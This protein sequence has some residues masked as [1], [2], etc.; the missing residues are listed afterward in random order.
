V[1]I[2][3]E[4]IDKKKLTFSFIAIGLVCL[5]LLLVAEFLVRIFRPQPVLYPRW[6]YS[7]E[8][9]HVLYKNA[10]MK[11]KGPGKWQFTY[12]INEYGYRGKK[13]PISNC[14]Q[15][16]TIVVLGDS[17][18]FGTGVDDGEEYPSVM[19]NYLSDNYDIIN[20]AVGGYGLTQEIRRFYE[21]GQLY[22]P[23]IVILQFCGNDPTENFYHRVTEIEDGIFIFKDTNN[24]VDWVKQYFSKSIIQRSQ[25]YSLFRQVAYL[26]FKKRHI[27]TVRTELRQR[28]SEESVSPREEFHNSLLES[29]AKDLSGKGT[30]LMMISVN[31]QLDGF[32][33]IKQKVSELDQN[34]YLKYIEVAPWFEN[35]E[36][37]DSPE[38]HKWGKKAHR[39]VGYKLASYINDSQSH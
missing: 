17:Y 31:G 3:G 20:L 35:V 10:T 38:G 28:N 34:G 36:N 2:D 26:Y 33:R 14:Y 24:S 4:M 32:P 29:F 13:I 6:Q 39:I 5:I 18:S 21:F 15:K 30:H 25:L 9:G 7:P 1:R 16:D 22:Q 19:T 11:H 27:K 23:K 37:Y 8:Y 12:T